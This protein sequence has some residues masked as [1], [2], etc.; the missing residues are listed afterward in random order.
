MSS[1]NPSPGLS[2]SPFS[3]GF[4]PSPGAG[5]YANQRASSPGFGPVSNPV[6]SIPGLRQPQSNLMGLLG[7]P[8]PFMGG[9]VGGYRDSDDDLITRMPV[10]GLSYGGGLF[11]RIG[12]GTPLR[13]QYVR[14]QP[15]YSPQTTEGLLPGTRFPGTELNQLPTP[16]GEMGLPDFMRVMNTPEYNGLTMN[17]WLRARMGFLGPRDLNLEDGHA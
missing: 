17:N 16:L 5:P 12:Y 7:R 11:D 2:R 1:F 8:I 15:M 4:G 6:Q 10:P 13:N 9:A 14:P 3:Y